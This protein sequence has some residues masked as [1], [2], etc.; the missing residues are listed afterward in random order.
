MEKKT[1]IISAI[2]IFGLLAFG[3]G[4]D[5]NPTG[6]SK[7]TY[8]VDAVLVKNTYTDSARVDVLLL[9]NGDTC[10][11]ATIRLN[12]TV[13]D[14]SGSRYY[15]A[16]GA[17]LIPVDT[18]YTLSIH[19]STIFSADLSI[20]LADAVT[21]TFSGFRFYNGSAEAVS[22]TG[23]TKGD[24]Y[25]LATA[26]PES[27]AVDTGYSAY[28][29]TLTGAI[30]AEA[31]EDG[32]S[33]RIIGVH[34]IYVTAYTGAPIDSPL[35]PFDLPKILIPADNVSGTQISGRAAGIVISAPDSIDVS[36]P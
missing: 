1:A 12:T 35:L 19:D 34:K 21:I 20:R 16:F 25:I 7:D 24:G 11:T 8:V 22:W 29:T 33:N 13:L 30:P 28:Y 17:G 6:G 2:L 4:G 26:P 36:A 31:F 18:V 9:K 10:S 23:G 3:C 32:F 5:L 27:A 15:K 14:T